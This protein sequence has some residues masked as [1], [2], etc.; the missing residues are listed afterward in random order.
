MRFGRRAPRPPDAEG[1][2]RM[3]EEAGGRPL[4]L[5]IV[6]APRSGTTLVQQFLG[7]HPRF[8]VTGETRYF[9]FLLRT[10]ARRWLDR[11]FIEPRRFRQFRDFVQSNGILVVDPATPAPRNRS[12]AV[13]TFIDLMD[14]NMRRQGRSA[15]SEKTPGHIFHVEAIEA[16]TAELHFLHILRRPEKIFYSLRTVYQRFPQAWRLY[17][18]DEARA[19]VINDSFRVIGKY[20]S[21]AGHSVVCLE[22]LL[23]HTEVE[24]RRL[25]RELDIPTTEDQLR[26]MIENHGQVGVWRKDEVWKQGYTSLDR[27]RAKPQI[28]GIDADERARVNETLREA[29]EIY[30]WIAEER[31][32][33]PPVAATGAARAAGKTLQKL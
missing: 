4:R 8:F 25:V 30:R 12:A 6:G 33:D 32:A 18:S 26:A 13:A 23:S 9:L 28:A 17:S 20:C 16:E 1:M 10:D 11:Y 27:D 3:T 31:Q 5:M 7:A 24:I 2:R 29:N 22:Q 15:W 14:A 21:A 19:A